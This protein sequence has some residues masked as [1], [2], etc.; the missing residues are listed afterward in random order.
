MNTILQAFTYTLNSGLLL[1]ETIHGSISFLFSVLIYKKTKELKLA[2]IPLIMAYAPDID[3]LINYWIYHGVGFNLLDFVK[4]E[5]FSE[6]KQVFIPF[7]ALEWVLVLSIISV[8][9][10][11]KSYI[12]ATNLGLIAHLVWDIITLKSVIYYSIIF[13]FITGFRMF[14]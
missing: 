7:H 10:G 2:V 14:T 8:K 3:H 6:P 12:T 1:D 11:W 9:R 5:Y 4:M 13:R